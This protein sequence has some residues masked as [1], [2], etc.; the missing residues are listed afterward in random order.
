[1]HILLDK[2][3]AFY[4]HATEVIIKYSVALILL[5]TV[6]LFTSLS[7]FFILSIMLT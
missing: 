2:V 1:M 6:I 7:S 4:K 5:F 3:T